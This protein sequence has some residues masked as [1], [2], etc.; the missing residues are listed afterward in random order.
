MEL[1][2]I[3]STSSTEHTIAWAELI[4][5][6]GSYIIQEGYA[7]TILVLSPNSTVTFLFTNGKTGSVIIGHGIAHIHRTIIT[8]LVSATA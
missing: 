1:H 7:P 8:I 4:T 6:K 5:P 3:T 2:I